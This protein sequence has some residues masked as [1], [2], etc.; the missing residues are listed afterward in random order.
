MKISPNTISVIS[1]SLSI[2]SIVLAFYTFN[3]N[4]NSTELNNLNTNLNQMISISIEYPYLEDSSFISKWP[5]FRDSSEE[6]YLR[7][8]SY[9]IYTFNFLQS[10][11]SYYDYD[12]NKIEDFVNVDEIIQTHET[13]WKNPPSGEDPNT[14]GYDEKFDRFV[15]SIL[16][17]SNSTTS[18]FKTSNNM[19]SIAS[20]LDS[21]SITNIIAFVTFLSITGT[22]IWGIKSTQKTL[23]LSIQQKI[24]ETATSKAYD[25]NKMWEENSL[26][27]ENANLDLMNLLVISREIIQEQISLFGRNYNN[28]EDS[29][30]SIYFIFYKQIKPE[31][32]Q[33]L[34]NT[35][36]ISENLQPKNE[37][38][39]KMI[40][41]SYAVFKQFFE[42]PL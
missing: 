23:R 42:Q 18:P 10:V 7:Y 37:Y 5:S 11:C 4:Y 17:T 29:K 16:S 25:C 19:N 36:S 3:K 13:W 33:W 24:V 38:Y 40:I 9:C 15:N 8:N 41:D 22:L 20:I 2:S 27:Q 34:K 21:Q 6:R 32:R 14:K 39:E 35:E 12:K 28:L 30:N 26:S 1:I 31:I